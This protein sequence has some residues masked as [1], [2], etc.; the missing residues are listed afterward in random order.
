MSMLVSDLASVT[1]NDVAAYFWEVEWDILEEWQ[2]ELYKKVIKEIHGF[3]ISRGCP[4][5]KPDILIHFKQEGFKTE[6]QGA[7]ERGNLPIIGT[8]EELHEAGSSGYNP[9]PTVEILKMELIYVSDQLKAKDENFDIRADDEFSRKSEMQRSRYEQQR[10]ELKH[11]EPSRDS[12]NPSADW[13]GDV[14]RATPPRVKERVQKGKKP[15]LCT[16]REINS[17][18]CTELVQT[19]RPS[20]G[21]QPFQSADTGEKFTANSHFN[22]HQ[23]ILEC[24]NKLIKKSSHRLIQQNDRNEKKC[25]SVEGEKRTSKKTNLKAYR[26]L[27]KCSHCEKCFTCRAELEKHIRIHT[28]KRSFQCTECKKCFTCKSQL[29][30]H[31]IIHTEEKPFA[32]IEWENCLANRYELKSYEIIH[33]GERLFTCT[34]SEKESSKKTNITHRKFHQSRKSL[35]CAHCDKNFTYQAELERHVRIHMIERPF[36]C[37]ECKKKFTKKSKLTAHKKIHKGDELFTCKE[38]EKCFSCR[39]QLKIHQIFHTGEKPLKYSEC[40]KNFALN[41]NFSTQRRLHTRD[42]PFKCSECDKSFTYKSHLTVHEVSHMREKPFKCSECGKN[43]SY[44]YNL[45]RHEMIHTGEKPFKCSECGKCFYY[46]HNLKDHGVTHTKEK[47][48]KCPECDKSFNHISNLRR[49]ER[50]HTEL[51]RRA[52]EVNLRDYDHTQHTLA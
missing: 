45:R 15:D 6:P 47:P 51:R 28:G 12:P 35:K 41:S 21:E 14:S 13:K 17:Q 37:T 36:Q 49:H 22:E 30:I 9:D 40:E 29:K 11:L 23:E 44:R 43:F 3:L 46:M 26:Q 32:C 25:T 16:E 42:K 2:K 39:S 52:L 38:C 27:L 5:V 10:E 18:R 20:E 1:F 24:K 8:C 31:Q 4:R 48:Y 7:E 34:E 19:E 50:I 33:P